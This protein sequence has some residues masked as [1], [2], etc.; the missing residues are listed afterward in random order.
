MRAVESRDTGGNIYM[1]PVYLLKGLIEPH[2]KMQHF[3]WNNPLGFILSSDC[4][5]AVLRLPR[6]TENLFIGQILE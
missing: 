2:P 4:D 1:L 3:S 5:W 6:P